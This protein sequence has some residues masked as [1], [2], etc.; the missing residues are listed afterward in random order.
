MATMVTRVRMGTLL[1]VLLGSS[2]AAA[3]ESWISKNKLRDPLSNQ[4]C[5][6]HID[7]AEVP[8]SG[9]REVNGGYLLAETGET[10]PYTRVIWASPEGTWVRCRYMSG[11]KANQTR[12]LIGPPPSL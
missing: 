9:V 4:W 2:F 10:I 6:N 11:E 3:H 12:C 5:C 8:Q 1:V 7:C